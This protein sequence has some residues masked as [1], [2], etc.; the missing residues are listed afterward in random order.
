MTLHHEHSIKTLNLK[1][2]RML[3]EDDCCVVRSFAVTPG[4]GLVNRGDSVKR[5]TRSTSSRTAAATSST[6]SAPSSAVAH[7]PSESVSSARS[8]LKQRYRAASSGEADAKETG[9]AATTAA[10]KKVNAYKVMLL[11]DHGVGKTALIQQFMTSEYM[12]AVDSSFG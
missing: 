1:H 11:G 9:C 10:Q 4:R 8:S 6:S 2:F 7:D 3:E 5:K 12:G